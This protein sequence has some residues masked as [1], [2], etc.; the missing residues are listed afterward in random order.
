M[1]GKE[2]TEALFRVI[3]GG[4]PGNAMHFIDKGAVMCTNSLIL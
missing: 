4:D 3:K 1:S 2:F